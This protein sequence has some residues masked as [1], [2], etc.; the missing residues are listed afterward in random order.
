MVTRSDL[1]QRKGEAQQ[2]RRPGAGTPRALRPGKLSKRA[3]TQR[4][5]R[6][7]AVKDAPHFRKVR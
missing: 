1:R 5:P 6:G 4:R 3:G 2:G 7:L